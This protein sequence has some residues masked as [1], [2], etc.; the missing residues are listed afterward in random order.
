MKDID[1]YGE[2][3][4]RMWF[5]HTLPD[6]VDPEKVMFPPGPARDLFLI[7]TGFAEETGEAL[8][9]IKKR[10]RD[11]TMDDEALI[12]ELGDAAFYWARLCRFYGFKPSSVLA[13][14]V[15]K[16]ESRRARG[17]LRGDGDDR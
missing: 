3:T 9:K 12:K 17:K 4:E 10:E 1:Q 14:N 5:S 15:E 2:F 8:G 13:A 11:N 7:T 16:L 6:G